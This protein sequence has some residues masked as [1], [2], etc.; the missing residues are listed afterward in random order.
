MWANAA[1]SSIQDG[2]EGADAGSTWNRTLECVILVVVLLVRKTIQVSLSYKESHFF[3][4]SPVS[5]SSCSVKSS[6][7]IPWVTATLGK[8]SNIRLEHDNRGS[9]TASSL[10]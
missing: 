4:L 5:L 10:A 1:T 6:L 8:L 7:R 2:V 9:I 3:D